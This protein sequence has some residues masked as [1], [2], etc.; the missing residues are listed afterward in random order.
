MGTDLSHAMWLVSQVINLEIEIK[1][2]D[3]ASQDTF[4]SENFALRISTMHIRNFDP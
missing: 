3:L 4:I 1:A 2:D